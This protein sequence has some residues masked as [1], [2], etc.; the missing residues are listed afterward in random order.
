MSESPTT[1]RQSLKERQEA[2][3]KHWPDHQG[4][5]TLHLLSRWTEP[6]FGP[7]RCGAELVPLTVNK[8]Y[9]TVRCPSCRVLSTHRRYAAN[10]RRG[11]L[12]KRIL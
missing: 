5:C 1:L 6:P 9:L 7:Y 10:P 4:Y 12:E 8:N 11:P 2:M 3:L